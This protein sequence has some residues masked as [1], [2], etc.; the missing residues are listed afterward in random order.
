MLA[1]RKAITIYNIHSRAFFLN[2]VL[3]KPA[4]PPAILL[5]P[6]RT[7]LPTQIRDFNI[8]C[9]IFLYNRLKA[10]IAKTEACWDILNGGNMPRSTAA[11]VHCLPPPTVKV[12]VGLSVHLEPGQVSFVHVQAFPF[13]DTKIEG[14]LKSMLDIKSM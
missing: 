13:F 1:F 4:L 8:I 5:F 3:N 14:I 12:A 10:E 11:H 2:V 6:R 9:L 7:I